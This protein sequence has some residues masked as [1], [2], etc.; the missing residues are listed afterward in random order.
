MQFS[1]SPKAWEPWGSD[2]NTVSPGPNLKAR[3]R[4]ASKA[5]GRRKSYPGSNR[6][7]KWLFLYLFDPLRPLMAWVIPINIA[8]T[9]PVIWASL[10]PGKLTHK[11]IHHTVLHLRCS[12]LGM[13]LFGYLFYLNYAVSIQIAVKDYQ[14]I[15]N[16]LVY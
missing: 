15:V 5:K 13:D 12:A 1:L 3:D 4:G 16:D 11:V 7:S 10:S 6:E 8:S 2:S 14:V 9:L